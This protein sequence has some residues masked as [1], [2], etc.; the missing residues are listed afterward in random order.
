MDILEEWR[1]EGVN[2]SDR[3]CSLIDKFKQEQEKS[4]LLVENGGLS[5]NEA[6]VADPDAVADAVARLKPMTEK[7]R[8]QYWVNKSHR[9]FHV[10]NI[11]E[12]REK[13]DTQGLLE[14]LQKQATRANFE[15]MQCAEILEQER[16]PAIQEYLKKKA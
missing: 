1:K 10:N 15:C 3:I 12:Y 11:A 13:G 16:E 14:Y 5:S 9:Q 6:F 8:I 4:K 2:V 7:E